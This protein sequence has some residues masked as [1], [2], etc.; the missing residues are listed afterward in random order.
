MISE[1]HTWDILEDIFKREGFVHHQTSTYSNFLNSGIQR[2]ITEEPEIMIIPKN[3]KDKKYTKYT[4]SFSDVYIPKPSVMEDRELREFYPSEARQRDLTYDAP[5]YATIT[6]TTEIDG[7]ENEVNK[8]FRVVLGRIP[9]MLRSSHCYLSNMTPQERIKAGEC[10]YDEG[11]YFIIR[12]KERVL[13]SQIRGIYNIPLV[14]EQKPG[15]KIKYSCELRS[16]SEETGHS[17]LIQA[18]IGSDDST[19]A[20]SIPHIKDNIPMGIVF[21]A[22]GY[23]CNDICDLI[24]L[25]Y[26]KADKYIRIILN[27]S[28]IIEDDDPHITRQNALKYIGMRASNPVKETDQC[29]YAEQILENEIFPHMG[30]TSTTREKAYILGHMVHKLLATYLGLRNLDDRDNYINKRVESPGVLCHELFRQLFKK[31]INTILTQIEK[32]KQFPDVMSIIPRLTDITKGFQHCFGTGNWG[33]PKNSYV[34]AGVAQILSRL[35]YGATVSNLRRLSIPIGKESKNTV[36]RQINPSQIMFICPVE[37]FDPNTKILMW[38]GTVKTAGNIVVGDALI[39][40]FGNKTIVKSTCSGYKNMYDVVPNKV[41]FDTH[42][43]TD[44]HILTLRIWQHKVIHKASRLGR[45]YTHIVSYLNRDV[46]KYQKKYFKCVEDAQNFVD[47]FT[48]DNTIDI[49]IEQYLALDKTTKDKLVLYKNPSMKWN[50]ISPDTKFQLKEAGYG[51]FVGWQLKDPRGRF[52]LACG[53]ITHNTPEGAPVGTVLNLSLLTRISERTPTVLVKEVVEQCDNITLIGDF[54]GPNQETKVFLNGIIIGMCEEPYE[55]VKELKTLR[56]INMIPWDVSISYNDDDDEIHV[57]SDEGRLLRPVFTVKDD[58]LVGTEKDGTNW[59]ELLKKGII[60]YIDNAE[61]N[62]A[63]IAFSQKE[64]TKYHNDYCEIAPAMM[65]GV[66]GNIIP[67]SDHS[68]SPRNTYQSAMGKQ[69]MSIFALS[70]LIRADTVVHVLNTPQKPVVG[71][72]GA[73]IM[74]FNDMPS[75]IN[76]IVAIACYGGYN[77]EDSVLINYSAI[78]RGMFWATTYKTHTE[79]EKKEGYMAEKIGIPPLNNRRR[80]ANYGLLDDN[81]VVRLRHPK[82]NDKDNNIHGGGAV[83]VQKGD[84]IIGKLAVQYEKDGGEKLNDCSLVIKRGEE[85]YIDRIFDTITPNGYRLVKVVIRKTRIPEVGDKFASRAAQ[86]GTVGMVYRQEDMPFTKDGIVPD[87][88]MN[89]HAIPS[90]HPARGA[91]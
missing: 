9:I 61:A 80:D 73:Q 70:H 49:T 14:I 75:G 83:Y 64:L 57:C 87:I 48:D 37:C 31:Y 36:I 1:K 12:G 66:M 17:V 41:N 40:D 3:D 42:R 84:V 85:G 20:F 26:S 4:V 7:Q 15:D 45:S 63:V 86:K 33:V 60:T 53:T 22:L 27:D 47:T 28:Y 25:T 18:V 10:P 16:M 35:S 72:R 59:Y 76:T 89:P 58:K 51:P 91:W 56:E 74:G 44:N 43:V 52:T 46:I 39:D 54:E 69:A 78:Q 2:I 19:L 30:V 90:Q 71:T 32:K 55:L 13:I 8:Y 67:F 62:G 21:K 50:T 11:G 79:S 6:E 81:G 24:S 38:N 34:R 5:I 82:W 68:Q 77:Q 23:G 88:I 65:M 29:T